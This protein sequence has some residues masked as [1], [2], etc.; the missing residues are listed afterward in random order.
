[1]LRCTEVVGHFYEFDDAGFDEWIEIQNQQRKEDGKK[2][3]DSAQIKRWST[4][5]GTTM[6]RWCLEG[7][8][9]KR[10]SKVMIACHDH[11][12]KFLKDEEIELIETEK[13]VRNGMSYRGTL[14]AHMEQWG[15]NILGDLK[16]WKCWRW[17][18]CIEM[19][20]P[21]EYSHN[22][23]NLAKT[24][25]Q[26]DLYDEA[27]DTVEYDSRAVFAI[28]PL[29]VFQKTF[30]RHSKKKQEALDWAKEQSSKTNF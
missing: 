5:F 13:E 12:I 17:A 18:P 8:A 9:P 25:L 28:N 20:L 22:A 24:N 16:F 21:E 3:L 14:D 26:T 23:N 15:C 1:M 11:W 6:H 29:G 4:S 19:D 10:P 7:I 30:S 2:L 27:D